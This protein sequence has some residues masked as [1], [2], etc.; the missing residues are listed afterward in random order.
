[1]FISVNAPQYTLQPVV[2]INEKVPTYHYRILQQCY[3]SN[4]LSFQFSHHR[5]SGN[6]RNSKLFVHFILINK[7]I[8]HEQ[9]VC[10]DEFI[11][12]VRNRVT[13]LFHAMLAID[14]RYRGVELSRMY[15]N[16][17]RPVMKYSF[18]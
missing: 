3:R 7:T 1:M 12:I 17:R 18:A 2:D 9:V 4:N 13:S 5:T 16:I 10:I 6:K 15:R 8:F 11:E 14:R